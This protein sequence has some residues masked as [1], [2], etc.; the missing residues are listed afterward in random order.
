MAFKSVKVLIATIGLNLGSAA[1]AE[2]LVY[3]GTKNTGTVFYYDADTIRRNSNNTVE[4]WTKLDQS[5]DKTVSARTQRAKLRIDCSAETYG[6]TSL[7]LYRSDGSVIESFDFEYPEMWSIP[8]VG[9]IKNL[10]KIL[11]PR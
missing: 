6:A 8:P 4:V 5:K 11:C 3:F 1:I 9:H 10:F 2:D 7:Y